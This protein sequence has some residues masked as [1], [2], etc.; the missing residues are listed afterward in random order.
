MP[1]GSLPGQHRS[2]D[3]RLCYRLSDC[4][5]VTMQRTATH[6]HRV[7]GS[8]D[9]CKTMGKLW[10]YVRHF[11]NH[12]KTMGK[13]CRTESHQLVETHDWQYWQRRL[14]VVPSRPRWDDAC[15]TW[16][17][18]L[19]SHFS[20]LSFVPVFSVHQCSPLH[21]RPSFLLVLKGV[22][23]ISCLKVFAAPQDCKPVQ[24]QRIRS[25]SVLT[26]LFKSLQSNV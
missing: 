14:M 25:F 23:A 8:H 1:W 12:W 11:S 2:C 15:L 13:V 19:A 3:P 7:I 10:K 24:W 5:L 21:R 26:A 22:V 9:L 17:F 16:C 20:H 4:R 18:F 6:G